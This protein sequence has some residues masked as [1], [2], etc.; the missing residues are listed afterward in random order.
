[1][2]IMGTQ[3]DVK[4]AHFKT[5]LGIPPRNLHVPD[6]KVTALDGESH[7]MLHDLDPDAKTSLFL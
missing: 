4:V 1:M 3:R 7:G 6:A 5:A 2:A